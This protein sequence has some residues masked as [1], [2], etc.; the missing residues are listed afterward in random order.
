MPTSCMGN[1]R[2][3]F[4]LL[5]WENWS[6]WVKR[7]WCMTVSLKIPVGILETLI[8]NYKL[9]LLPM[10]VCVCYSTVGLCYNNNS[11]LVHVLRF[12]WT[13]C[14]FWNQNVARRYY[15][16]CSYLLAY[17]GILSCQQPTHALCTNLKKGK[18]YLWL[19][20]QSYTV[21]PAIWDHTV[22]LAA[23][24][25]WMFLTLTPAI[26]A[27]TWFTYSGVIEGW[28]DLAVGF[29]LRWFIYSQMIIY[30]VNSHF[31]ASRLAVKPLDHRFD[32]LPLHNQ[33]TRLRS[34]FSIANQIKFDLRF[35]DL[36]STWCSELI[37]DQLCFV[38]PYIFDL[39][40]RDPQFVDSPSNEPTLSH[41]IGWVTLQWCAKL[42][43]H[44]SIC[45]FYFFTKHY[46]QYK[47]ISRIDRHAWNLS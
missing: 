20:S 14:C 35:T 38:F 33:G 15:M 8:N 11:T 29:L 30:P 5:C 18:R 4:G 21:S 32:A 37:V 25:R 45:P 17:C 10:Y 12:L 40:L 47:L 26:Q 22:L 16:F 24:R 46:T 44:G 13:V 34:S 9:L 31:I 36:R 42:N 41:L 39:Q 1:T 3:W 27:V 6:W 28:V 19:L 2:V 43:Q 23:W 7:C